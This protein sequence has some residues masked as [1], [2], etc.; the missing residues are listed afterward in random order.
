MVKRYFLSARPLLD[1]GSR[2]ADW[3]RAATE[4]VFSGSAIR[5]FLYEELASQKDRTYVPFE[6]VGGNTPRDDFFVGFNGI[7]KTVAHLGGNLE[8]DVQ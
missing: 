6:Q 2:K 4:H 8:A 1:S 3:T 7:Q 5:G